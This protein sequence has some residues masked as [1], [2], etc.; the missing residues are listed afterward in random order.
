NKAMSQINQKVNEYNEQNEQQF[1]QESNNLMRY[2]VKDGDNQGVITNTVNGDE[3]KVLASM[4]YGTDNFKQNVTKYKVNEGDMG[5][6]TENV[7]A[8]NSLRNLS[9]GGD[10][11]VAQ[12]VHEFTDA[13]RDMRNLLSNE[14]KQMN[15]NDNV[16]YNREMLDYLEETTVRNMP[17]FKTV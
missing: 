16:T 6:I 14:V 13:K 17:E 1:G 15:A 12:T 2:V 11:K 9:L 8:V 10:K 7:S 5:Q 3:N 4:V